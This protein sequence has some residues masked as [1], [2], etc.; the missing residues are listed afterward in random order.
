MSFAPLV[1][2]ILKL[3]SRFIENKEQERKNLE[4][5]YKKL[6]HL[7]EY[8]GQLVIFFDIL[9]REINKSSKQYTSKNKLTKL[10]QIKVLD[11]LSEDLGLKQISLANEYL[12]SIYLNIDKDIYKKAK[13]II[14]QLMKL[15]DLTKKHVINDNYK[16]YSFQEIKDFLNSANQ[17]VNKLKINKKSLKLKIKTELNSKYL[18]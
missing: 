9:N 18:I 8:C 13:N 10:I 6:I 17:I 2:Y 11:I 12:E 3:F 5:I 7:I 4:E 16:K 14:K 1:N 15:Y